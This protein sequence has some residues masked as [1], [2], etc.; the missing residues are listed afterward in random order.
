MLAHIWP[1][2]SDSHMHDPE[3]EFHKNAVDIIKTIL[4]G[5]EKVYTICINTILCLTISNQVHGNK[6]H[7]PR[8]R[9]KTS[10]CSKRLFNSFNSLSMVFCRSACSHSLAATSS[11]SLESSPAEIGNCTSNFEW[12]RKL[13]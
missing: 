1:M 13:K 10:F 4:V 6:M 7:K 9:C 3:L 5:Q 8:P 12:T 2:F 11:I